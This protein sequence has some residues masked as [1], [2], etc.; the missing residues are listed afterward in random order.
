MN[1]DKLQGSSHVLGTISSPLPATGSILLPAI[2]QSEGPKPN[3]IEREKNRPHRFRVSAAMGPAVRQ[4]QAAESVRSPND[5]RATLP[6]AVPLSLLRL[7]PSAKRDL[8]LRA[9]SATRSA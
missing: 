1:F 9:E 3:R 6:P 5:C 2:S 8:V 7:L 4:G